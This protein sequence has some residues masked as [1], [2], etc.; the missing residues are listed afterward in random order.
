LISLAGSLIARLGGT[1][2]V[3]LRGPLPVL[4]LVQQ[5]GSP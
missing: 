1:M 2:L 4:L 3:R 5:L